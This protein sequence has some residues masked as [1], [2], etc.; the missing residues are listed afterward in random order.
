MTSQKDTRM[1]YERPT[2]R[3]T[4]AYGVAVVTGANPG[5]GLEVVR[6]LAAAEHTRNGL[7]HRVYQ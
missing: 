7:I 4:E 6:Q 5:I 3:M 2:A 1:V